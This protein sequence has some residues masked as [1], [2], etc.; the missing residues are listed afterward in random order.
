MSSWWLQPF[1]NAVRAFR[2]AGD[3]TLVRAAQAVK[4]AMSIVK[5]ENPETELESEI[6]LAL[7]G[8]GPQS[9]PIAVVNFPEE[10]C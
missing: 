1:L 7:V 9:W 3:N 10:C 8:V 5:V 4:G 2:F 6:R